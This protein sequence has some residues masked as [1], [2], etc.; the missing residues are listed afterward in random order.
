MIY[1]P[2]TGGERN[3]QDTRLARLPRLLVV[4]TINRA[5]ILEMFESVR[6]Q[7]ELHFLEYSRNYEELL[8]VDRYEPYGAVRTWDDY[9]SADHLLDQLAP[10]RIVFLSISALN[11]VALR[12][13]ARERGIET[14]H[15]EHGYRLPLGQLTGHQPG[16]DLSG[17]WRRYLREPKRALL[18]HRFLLGSLA[19]RRGSRA[20][21]TRYVRDVAAH[22]ATEEILQRAAPLRRPDRYVSYSA[23]CFAYHRAL[24]RIQPGTEK[25]AFVGCPQFDHFVARP[26]ANTDAEAVILVDHQLHNTGIMGWNDGFRKEWALRLHD[27][28]SKRGL[29]LYVKTHPGDRSEVWTR[30][31]HDDVELIDMPQLHELAP[32]ARVVLGVAS[33]LQ[34]PLAGLPHTAS[35]SL[36]IHP[37]RGPSLS[38]RIVQAGVMKSAHSFDQLG[39]CL[40]A[41]DNLVDEQS[42]HKEAFVERFL[43]RLDGRSGA[44]FKDQ[45]VGA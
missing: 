18:T 32:R 30:W 33:T 19:A 31:L 29:R 16:P 15:V 44:R 45:L 41:A 39:D 43:Y 9:R 3:P 8:D 2:E 28:V 5:D 20:D 40:S 27:V 34:L 10:D 6:S 4:G 42:R 17:R 11:Q 7:A 26:A 22:G 24:D 23:E 21:L 14:V 37:H 1:V 13:A 12:L 38:Q 35:I 25:V 36:E